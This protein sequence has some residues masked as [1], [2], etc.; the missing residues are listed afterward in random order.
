MAANKFNPNSCL[1]VCVCICTRVCRICRS[2]AV[3][4]IQ[5]C[6]KMGLARDAAGAPLSNHTVDCGQGNSLH[7]LSAQRPQQTHFITQHSDF[8]WM[9]IKCGSHKP[10][11]LSARRH[12]YL[13]VQPH[14]PTNVGHRGINLGYTTSAE[15][16]V[17]DPAT[18]CWQ[19]K[20]GVYT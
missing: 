3:I 5:R 6:V 12:A 7:L 10:L 2:L 17:N 16:M 19:S 11:S 18:I 4:F 1:S 20:R 9:K 8:I 13:K 15:G 14:K